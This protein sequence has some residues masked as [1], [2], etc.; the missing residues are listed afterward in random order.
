MMKL[1]NVIVLL[2]PPASLGAETLQRAIALR[3]EKFRISMKLVSFGVQKDADS[4]ADSDVPETKPDNCMCT[5]SQ[6]ARTE[7]TFAYLIRM[8]RREELIN[9]KLSVTFENTHPAHARLIAP[10][11][12]L[13]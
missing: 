5:K 7:S 6:S 8:L 2:K 4:F 9:F 13:G 10:E 12:I 3:W 1:Q 11:H